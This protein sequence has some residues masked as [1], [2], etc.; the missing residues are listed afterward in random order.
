MDRHKAPPAHACAQTRTCVRSPPSPHNTRAR[1]RARTHTH[2]HT[3]THTWHTQYHMYWYL[4]E[5]KKKEKKKGTMPARFVTISLVT[6]RASI[7]ARFVIL[8]TKRAVATKRA[9]SNQIWPHVLADCLCRWLS[10]TIYADMECGLLQRWGRFA[11]LVHLII[12]IFCA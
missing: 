8:V 11:I 2:T 10:A 4:S 12:I 7:A 6:K 9:S 3:L 5:K 1:A